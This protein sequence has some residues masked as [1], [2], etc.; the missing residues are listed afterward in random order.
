MSESFTHRLV[1]SGLIATLEPDKWRPGCWVLTV[2]GTPQSHVDLAD[3]TALHFDYIARMG[4]MIDRAFP[5]GNAITALH[6]GAGAMT[7]PRYIATTRPG[8]RQQVIELERDLVDFVR[9]HCPLPRAAQ[10]RCRYGDARDMLGSL[11]SGLLGAVDLIVID[12]YRGARTPSHVTTVEFYEQVKR[13]LAPSGLVL[14]N[15]TDGP[16]L[17]FAHNQFATLRYVFGDVFGVAE[18]GIA[19]GK[20]YG[21]IVA[22]ALADGSTPTWAAGLAGLGPHPTS[23]IA[24]ADARAW[25]S[26]G[27]VVTDATAVDSP[28]PSRSL[29]RD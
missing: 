15:L 6:L 25:A 20:R 14:A 29:F 11:P 12:V 1:G 7:I 4:H 5:A 28:P 21:N 23:L 8:S 18:F 3:P 27:T 22:A 24:G 9:E 16:P 17:S 10:I 26:K 2:D 19:S 13:L